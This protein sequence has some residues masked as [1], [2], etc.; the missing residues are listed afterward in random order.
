MPLTDPLGSGVEHLSGT[1]PPT[2]P[3]RPAV[4]PFPRAGPTQVGG[5]HTPLA[6]Q[7]SIR[8]TNSLG[9]VDNHLCGPSLRI[10]SSSI[11]LLRIP[12]LRIPSNDERQAMP[13]FGWR[14]NTGGERGAGRQNISSRV[15]A[16]SVSLRGGSRHAPSAGSDPN[17]VPPFPGLRCRATRGRGMRRAPRT[18]IK[19]TSDL[20]SSPAAYSWASPN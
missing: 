15:P 16:W 11:P 19:N 2:L 4:A 5:D 14:P 20:C 8:L 7:S 10:S 1:L 13:R 9:G 18:G 6:T 3:H 17:L 12:S